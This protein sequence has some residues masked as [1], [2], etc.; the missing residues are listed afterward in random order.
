MLPK[1]RHVAAAQAKRAAKVEIMRVCVQH[2]APLKLERTEACREHPRSSV[3]GLDHIHV[4]D[5]VGCVNRHSARTSQTDN[6]RFHSWETLMGIGGV[7]PR[8]ESPWKTPP[9]LSFVG[10]IVK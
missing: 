2:C 4:D 3:R 10:K 7:G 9:T 1:L 6:S 8:H 5:L